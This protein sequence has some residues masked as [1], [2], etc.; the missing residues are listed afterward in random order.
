[1]NYP[2]SFAL[3]IGP[4]AL[5]NPEALREVVKAVLEEIKAAGMDCPV[6][7]APAAATVA[8]AATVTPATV[9]PAATVGHTAPRGPWES[10]YGAVFGTSFLRYTDAQSKALA[11]VSP[12]L[13]PAI[14]EGLAK[15]CIEHG[16]KNGDLRPELLIVG[17]EWEWTVPTS[18]PTLTP[19]PTGDPDPLA[20]TA[21]W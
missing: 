4:A 20:G 6:T 19:T 11:S 1:M 16:A 8:P 10:N 5:D 3:Q 7:V 21:N 12:A 14:R 13:V 15:F 18:A 17:D 9:A 2:V